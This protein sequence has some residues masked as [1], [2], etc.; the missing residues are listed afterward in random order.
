MFSKTFGEIRPNEIKL[1]NIS[2]FLS[3][4]KYLF[5]KHSDEIKYKDTMAVKVK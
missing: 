5:R 1:V 4:S 2:T 3:G